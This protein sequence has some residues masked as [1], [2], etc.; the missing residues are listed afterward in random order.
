MVGQKVLIVRPS[1]IARLRA[2]PYNYSV[3][4]RDKRPKSSPKKRKTKRFTTNE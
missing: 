1:S 4:V 2:G 3:L